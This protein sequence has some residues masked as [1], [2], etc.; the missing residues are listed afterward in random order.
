MAKVKSKILR[1]TQTRSRIGYKPKAKR[2]LDALGLHRMHQTVELEDCATLR[3]M[4]KVVEFLVKVEEA[5]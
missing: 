4:I 2:T 5:A 1:I 3:G